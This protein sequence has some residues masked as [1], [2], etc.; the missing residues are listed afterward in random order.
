MHCASGVFAADAIRR[1]FDLVVLT[2]DMNA[3]VAG[4]RRQIDEFNSSI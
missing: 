2:S 3:M 4:A 1:G